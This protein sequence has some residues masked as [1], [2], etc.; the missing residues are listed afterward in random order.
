MKRGTFEL[1]F[2]IFMFFSMTLEL[3]RK[4]C[5]RYR[6]RIPGLTNFVIFLSFFFYIIIHAIQIRMTE[7]DKKNL[8]DADN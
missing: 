7:D 6:E 5:E 1:I 8:T 3:D 4:I 2:F